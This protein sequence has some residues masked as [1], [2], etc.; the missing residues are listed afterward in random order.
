VLANSNEVALAVKET[1][2]LMSVLTEKNRG[3]QAGDEQIAESSK[4]QQV[5]IE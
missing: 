3:H 2:Q 4:V 5:V 1:G